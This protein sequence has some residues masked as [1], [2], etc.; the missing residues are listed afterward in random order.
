MAGSARGHPDL[1]RL[2]GRDLRN[3]SRARSL[4]MTVQTRRTTVTFTIRL[5]GARQGPIGSSRMGRH[6][7][8][9]IHSRMTA[10]DGAFNH[11][12]TPGIGPGPRLFSTDLTPDRVFVALSAAAASSAFSTTPQSRTM[13]SLTVTLTRTALIQ[14]EQSVPRLGTVKLGIS[15]I[16]LN[17]RRLQLASTR[18][19]NRA[20]ERLR[21]FGKVGAGRLRR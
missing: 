19:V 12:G 8:G 18:A 2:D 6:V 4:V 20:A 21:P 16:P 7:I 14:V 15:E 10:S 3:I 13:P 17:S 5:D 11:T 9:K 1:Y